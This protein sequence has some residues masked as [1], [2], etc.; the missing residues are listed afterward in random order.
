LRS[1]GLRGVAGGIANASLPIRVGSRRVAQATPRTPIIA[2]LHC[3]AMT[4]SG[5]P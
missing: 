2:P 4:A 3:A 5:S 1:Q